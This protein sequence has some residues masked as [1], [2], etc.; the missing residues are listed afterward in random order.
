MYEYTK[1]QPIFQRQSVYNC[2]AGSY[3]T[4]KQYLQ[5]EVT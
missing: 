5:L 4:Y 3:D 2:V 1:T